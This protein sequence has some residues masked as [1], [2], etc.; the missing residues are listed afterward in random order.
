MFKT[1]VWRYTQENHTSFSQLQAL[2]QCLG[3]QF[4][5]FGVLQKYSNTLSSHW[6]VINVN[7]LVIHCARCKITGKRSTGFGNVADV[8]IVITISNLL[9][10]M[11]VVP[12]N[13]VSIHMWPL[14]F[15]MGPLFLIMCNIPCCHFLFFWGDGPSE[16]CIDLW[17]NP[18]V[19]F[20]YAEK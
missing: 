16:V 8:A 2:H 18:P 4:P 1:M 5:L 6:T 19:C 13:V 11:I 14:I 7:F 12:E 9:T 10:N 15:H 20:M 3:P 17:L